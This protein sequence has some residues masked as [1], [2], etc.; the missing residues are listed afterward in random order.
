MK[1][2]TLLAVATLATGLLVLL[3]LASGIHTPYFALP[4]PEFLAD[5]ARRLD[6]VLDISSWRSWFASLDRGF[7]FLLFLPFVVAVVGLWGA[8]VRGE[9]DDEGGS[10]G[11]QP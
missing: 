3:I 11:R 7:A 5:M 10:G 4:L 9:D 8:Y 1:S 2:A 6:E